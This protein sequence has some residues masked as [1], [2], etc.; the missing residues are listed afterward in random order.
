MGLLQRVFDEAGLSTI[1]LTLVREITEQVKPSRALFVEHPFGFP[2][3]NIG[4]Q[5]LQRR[6]LLDCLE[7]AATM[8]TPGAIL[9]LP[10]RWTH[11]NLRELQLQ[12]KAH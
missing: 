11:D 9:D 4:E 10:Y 1:S 6:I 8:K 3:G 5:D 2:F 7:A 12:K